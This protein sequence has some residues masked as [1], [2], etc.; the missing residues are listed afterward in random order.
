VRVGAAQAAAAPW[1]WLLTRGGPA[2]PRG[3]RRL[4]APKTWAQRLRQKLQRKHSVDQYVL[5]LSVCARRWGAS[6]SR[7]PV[8]LSS[9]DPGV[10]W[11]TLDLQTA[12]ELDL[13]R[14]SATPAFVSQRRF[15]GGDDDHSNPSSHHASSGTYQA[16]QPAGHSRAR[17]LTQ[18]LTLSL[19][20]SDFLTVWAA[21]PCSLCWF[22][23]SED[24]DID[25]EI[26]QEMKEFLGETLDN[27]AG[28][29]QF[30]TWLFRLA[31]V[32][33]TQRINVQQLAL[34]LKAVANDHINTSNISF[35][36]VCRAA[37]PS[38]LARPRPSKPIPAHLFTLLTRR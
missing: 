16:A 33:D 34:I 27:E 3:T 25:E 8:R 10:C 28:R 24:D 20:L 13:G 29:Q 2:G 35:D 23:E 31:D 32:D 9:A 22:S 30:K 17:S 26:E 14:S 37:S 6:R 21:L 36:S 11:K 7:A 15:G 12:S 18:S 19:S 4:H 1:R 38:P 5:A